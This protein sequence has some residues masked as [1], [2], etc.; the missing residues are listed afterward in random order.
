MMK[1]EE[2]DKDT[3]GLFGVISTYHVASLLPFIPASLHRRNLISI[4]DIP[5]SSSIDDDSP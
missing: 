2:D 4:L 1:E 5:N 3:D